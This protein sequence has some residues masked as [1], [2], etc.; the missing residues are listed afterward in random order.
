MEL[1]RNAVDAAA[2]AARVDWV[3]EESCCQCPLP[4]QAANPLDPLVLALV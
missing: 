1:P 2:A 4:C 3:S